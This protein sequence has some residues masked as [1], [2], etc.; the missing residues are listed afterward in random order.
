MNP[1]T[2]SKCMDVK[3]YTQLLYIKMFYYDVF[4]NYHVY[5]NLI[6]NFF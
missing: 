3:N 1:T 4:K 5:L 2:A 6:P